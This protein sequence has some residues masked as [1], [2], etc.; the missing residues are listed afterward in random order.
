MSRFFRLIPIVLVSALYLSACGKA[1]DSSS[2]LRSGAASAGLQPAPPQEPAPIPQPSPSPQPQPS[3]VPIPPPTPAPPG[4]PELAYFHRASLWAPR[5]K[6]SL[7]WTRTVLSVVRARIKDLEHARD[8]EQF[9]PGYSSATSSQREICWLRL[10]GGVVEFESSFQPDEPPFHEGNGVYSVG[11]MALS[12]G[13][14]PNAPT[15]KALMNA[16]ENLICGV[17]KMAYLVGRGKAIAG[18]RNEGASAYWSTLRPAHKKWDPVR[19]RWLYL[20]KK[21]L[22]VA[23][24]RVFKEFR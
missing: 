3:P 23:R 21:E 14:C 24:T 17:N 9:C 10:V 4:N 6:T 12:A 20:G 16:V 13:E 18:P 2:T 22:I 7:P 15:Q 19:Q 11:L 1:P 5:V 8:I